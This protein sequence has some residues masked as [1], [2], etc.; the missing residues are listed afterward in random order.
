MSHLTELKLQLEEFETAELTAGAL[1]DIS[2]LRMQTI[3]NIFEKNR[4][5]FEGIAELYGTVRTFASKKEASLGSSKHLYVAITSNKRFYGSLMRDVI[6]ALVRALAASPGTNAL[7]VGR[8]GW[9]YFEQARRDQTT[10]QFLQA[11]DAPTPEEFEKLM[12]YMEGYDR[13]F[14]LYPKFINPFR[15]DVAIEDITR[16][17]EAAPTEKKDSQGPDDFG[18]LFEPEVS[19]ILAFFDAQ[20]KRVL[21]QGVLLEAE[22]AR[23]AARLVRMEEAQERAHEK[24]RGTKFLVRRENA[25]VSNSQLLETFAGFTKWG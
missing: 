15:Q 22:L 3:R 9:Q 16:S 19:Q 8:V 12:S 14:V 2:A 13:V 23:T 6:T 11:D 17:P 25:A 10:R 18:Y 1:E 20:V 21:F 24:V 7:V 5:F 4:A